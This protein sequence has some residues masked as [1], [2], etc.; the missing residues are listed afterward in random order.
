MSDGSKGQL[1]RLR[2]VTWNVNGLRN[3]IKRKKVLTYI[4][5][6]K[7]EVAFLQ[8]CH[9]SLK[10]TE[11]LC[12]GWIGQV[13]CNPGTSKSKGVIILVDKHIH[14][15]CLNQIKD[16]SGRILIVVAEI[17]GRVLIY[18]HQT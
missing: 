16:N 3:P 10:E 5:K 2:L 18:M 4:K 12:R 14:L 6:N 11:K 9:L 13:F 1:S 15:K 7:I 17:Q 8:E